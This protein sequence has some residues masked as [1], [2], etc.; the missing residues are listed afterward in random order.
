MAKR[1][2]VMA[3]RPGREDKTFWHRVGSGFVTEKEDGGLKI[4][5]VFDSL[6]LPGADGRV[7]VQLFEPKQ[8][9]QRE[10]LSDIAPPGGNAPRQP[11]GPRASLDD[12]AI[13]F[14][15]EWR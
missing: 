6:P 15:M 1:Y 12:D 7:G 10:R 8:D 5:I 4:G 11:A 13:P 14:E 2:D 9:G 3:P